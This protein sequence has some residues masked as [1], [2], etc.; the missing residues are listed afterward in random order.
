M[1]LSLCILFPKRYEHS[2]KYSLSQH[3]VVVTWISVN[4]FLEMAFNAWTHIL[5]ATAGTTKHSIRD[6]RYGCYLGGLF[7]HKMFS[8]NSMPT[9]IWI[10]TRFRFQSKKSH[11]STDSI[12][13]I[14]CSFKYLFDVKRLVFGFDYGLKI[15]KHRKQKKKI[16]IYGTLYINVK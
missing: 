9:Q 12:L 2:C 16:S 3:V 13:V 6:V 7:L 10:F 1:L 14:Y 4:V 8:N 11:S 5:R 15:L